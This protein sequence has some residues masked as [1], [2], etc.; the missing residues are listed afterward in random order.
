VRALA[1]E[2]R[3]VPILIENGEVVQVGWQGRGCTIPE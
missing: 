1:G 2:H 3:L